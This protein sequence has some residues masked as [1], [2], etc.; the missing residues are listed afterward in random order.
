M[1]MYDFLA[2][3]GILGVFALVAMPSIISAFYPNRP[4]PG[5]RAEKLKVLAEKL[6]LSYKPEDKRTLWEKIAVYKKRENIVEGNYKNKHIMVYDYRTKTA[7][8][9]DEG[10]YYIDATVINGMY[11][12][13]Q[14]SLEEIENIIEKIVTND[15]KKES[16]AES[17]LEALNPGDLDESF[18]EADI[19]NVR[20]N[21]GVFIICI[22]FI[23]A[24][25]IGL[26]AMLFDKM[27]EFLMRATL[28][29]V[30]LILFKVAFV[31]AKKSGYRIPVD[32]Y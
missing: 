31:L 23:G 12:K 27:S 9:A 19:R 15:L 28:L 16:L 6:G 20:F 4:T 7:F 10:N 21:S 25:D 29:V 17:G 18:D 1:D 26:Y 30:T 24:F 3:L 2:I 8:G 11:H 32:K 22:C 13:A 14:L 5:S